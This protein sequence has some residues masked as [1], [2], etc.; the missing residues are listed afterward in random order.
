MEVNELELIGKDITKTF[1]GSLVDISKEEDDGPGRARWSFAV[2]GQ[3]DK[4]GDRFDLGSI[5]MERERGT[6]AKFQHN[7]EP[8]GTWT[9]AREGATIYADVDFLDTTSGQ[10]CRKY[11][12]A[13][14][15][16]CQFSFR[17]K[18]SEYYFAEDVPGIAFKSVRAYETSPV[19]VGAG[20]TSLVTVKSDSD[21]VSKMDEDQVVVQ[22]VVKS[23]EEATPAWALSLQKEIQE[24]RETVN[25]EPEPTALEVAK[26]SIEGLTDL[27]KQELG[28]PVHRGEAEVR[29]VYQEVAKNGGVMDLMKAAN[30]RQDEILKFARGEVSKVGFEFRSDPED[31]AKATLAGIGSIQDRVPTALNVANRTMALNYL[32]MRPVNGN[33]VRAPHGFGFSDSDDDG[34]DGAG[35]VNPNTDVDVAVTGGSRGSGA[36]A[37][38]ASHRASPAYEGTGEFP[39]RSVNGSAPVPRADIEDDP[40]LIPILVADALR[41]GRQRILRVV[42]RGQS[43]TNVVAGFNTVI[44]GTNS[45]AVASGDDE[46]VKKILSGTTKGLE[47]LMGNLLDTVMPNVVFASGSYYTRIYTAQRQNYFV[48]PGGDSMSPMS[49]LAHVMGVPVI[50]NPYIASNTIL[51][52]EFTED[53]YFLGMRREIRVELSE[54][55][56]FSDDMIVVKVTARIAN[57]IRQADAF[58]QVTGANNYIAER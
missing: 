28:I 30:D 50:V 35:V 3:L 24:L 16:S 1:A 31:I 43:T 55:E 46:A 51:M 5:M 21:E 49:V 14:G 22:E 26:T 44:T 25:K 12:R 36:A 13:M 34:P 19:Y 20:D 4:D 8:A 17:A 32:P 54:D 6:V 23:G 42:M 33:M 45:T 53:T 56:N 40:S 18:V 9:M 27:E 10:D 11:V 48:A 15:D 41:A 39:V 37:D 38:G 2:E 7:N 52:G 47:F 29:K 57:C 58:H